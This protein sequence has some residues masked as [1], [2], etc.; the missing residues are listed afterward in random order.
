MGES[1]ERKKEEL[2]RLLSQ[3]PSSGSFQSV[4]LI[5]Q[6]NALSSEIRSQEEEPRNL[7]QP[8]KTYRYKDLSFP[9][10]DDV[11]VSLTVSFVSDGNIGVTTVFTPEGN[12]TE[13]Q[14][15]GTTAIGTGA[16]LRNGIT[17]CAS[18]IA[19]PI[20][21]EDEIRVQYLI[22]GQLLQ[23]HVNS[24]SENERPSIILYIKFPAL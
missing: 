4:D 9:V 2:K 13:I 17:I 7:I 22:N 5:R 3:I 15:A 1:L 24:K 23:E 16:D 14:D 8:R 6:V 12:E 20:P 19:N 10:A 11:E 21:D 18:E